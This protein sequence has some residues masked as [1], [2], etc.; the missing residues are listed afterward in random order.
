MSIADIVFRERRTG[1]AGADER[2]LRRRMTAAVSLSFAVH[3]LVTS[4]F[5][6]TEISHAEK[7]EGPPLRARLVQLKPMA[8]AAPAATPKPA[9]KPRP[10]P[11]PR[12]PGAA[13]AALPPKPATEPAPPAI[14]P[15]P[16]AEAPAPEPVPPPVE[17]AKPEPPAPEPAQATAGT[18][19]P[20]AFPERIDLE[21]NLMKGADGAPIGRVVHRFERQGDRYLIRST[22]EA[23]GLGA[24]FASGK[25]VQESTGLITAKGLRPERFVVQRGRA[26]RRETAAFDWEASKATLVAGGNTREWALRPGAQDMLSFIHQLSFIV[27]DASPPAVWVTSARKFDSVKIEVVGKEMVETDLGPIGAVHFRNTSGDGGFR[28]E[29]W[30]APDYGNL[31]VKI[32][33]RDNRGEDAEQVLANMKI[34]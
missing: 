6:W 33:L 26:D 22:T 7:A 25:F 23:T 14:E 16:V 30:L 17:T 1:W 27:G 13:E 34:R 20:L 32:R 24:L 10:K 9:A 5:D 28:F 29:V 4:G 8:A 11:A 3:L 12:L 2:S 18:E 21:F 31:P 19:A 15:P